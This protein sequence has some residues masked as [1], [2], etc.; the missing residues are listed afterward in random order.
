MGTN[1]T[2]EPQGLSPTVP[3]FPTIPSPREREKKYIQSRSIA[4]LCLRYRFHCAKIEKGLGCLREKTHRLTGA[5]DKKLKAPSKNFYVPIYVPKLKARFYLIVF[6][7]FTNPLTHH[8][9]PPGCSNG[10]PG[11]IFSNFSQP[12]ESK[13]SA[14]LSVKQLWKPTFFFSDSS[15]FWSRN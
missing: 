6:K 9:I 8:R 12:A 11:F 10:R 5:G 13:F 2:L 7:R 4:G 15:A 14:F 1:K 3:N